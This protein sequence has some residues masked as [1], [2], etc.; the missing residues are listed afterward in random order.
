MAEPATAAEISQLRSVVGSLSWL[1]RVCRPDISFGVNQL[2]AVQQKAQV[3]H[4]AEA[5]QILR[6]AMKDRQRGLFYPANIMK[7][8]EAV[9]VSVNDDASQ[10]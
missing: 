5:N 1:A 9:I 6:Y 2:Q 10:L 8:E 3:R 7:F 4:L